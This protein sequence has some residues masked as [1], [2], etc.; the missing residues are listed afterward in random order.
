VALT[1]D[2]VNGSSFGPTIKDQLTEE[3]ARKTSLEARGIG[4][5]T[6]SGVLATLL[7]G[8]SHIYTR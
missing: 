7:F 1:L 5:V 4:I 6:S 2:E 8:P 3:R